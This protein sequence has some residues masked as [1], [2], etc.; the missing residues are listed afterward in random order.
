M[1][2]IG[3]NLTIA[4]LAFIVG[5]IVVIIVWLG[6]RSEEKDS[7]STKPRYRYL[8]R[9]T[10]W[11]WVSKVPHTVERPRAHQQHKRKPRK[12]RGNNHE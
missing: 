8:G 3:Q 2:E 6:L 7:R 10:T 5:L 1:I 12:A 9:P 11:R 4:L